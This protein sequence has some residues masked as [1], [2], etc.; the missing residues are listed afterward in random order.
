MKKTAQQKRIESLEKENAKL[1]KDLQIEKITLS[2]T[3]G[4]ELRN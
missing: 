1:L 4:R 2:I 3:D